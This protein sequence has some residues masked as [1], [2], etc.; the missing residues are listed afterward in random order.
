MDL[1][2]DEFL[3][4][5]EW[6]QRE[7]FRRK[8]TQRGLS[9][10]GVEEMLHAMPRSPWEP[11]VDWPPDRVIFSLQ[12]LRELPKAK[13]L[14]NV[15]VAMVQRAYEMYSSNTDDDLRLR[16]DEP[17]LLAAAGGDAGL[18]L[19]A[20]KVLDQHPP[21]LL[22][23]WSGSGPE[24]TPWGRWLYQAVMPIFG[25][26]TTVEDYLAAQ[27][28]LVNET[29]LPLSPK[30]IKPSRQDERARAVAGPQTA[31]ATE[32]TS[33][34]NSKKGIFLSHAHADRPLADLLR[35]TLVLAGVPQQ[36][37]FYSSSRSTGI[38]YG[39]EVRPYL[40]RTLREAGLVIELISETFLT[41]PMCLMELGG[42][43]TLGTSTYPMVVPPLT[44][45]MAVKQIGNIHMGI[46]APES[47]IDDLFD[48]L[49]DRLAKD[50]DILVET[51]P[52][53]HAIREFKNMLPEKL[54]AV[55]STPGRARQASRTTGSKPSSTVPST[56][57]SDKAPTGTRAS[58]EAKGALR[59]KL[60]GGQS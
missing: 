11:I 32:V 17:V 43:W 51:R 39:E 23:G 55:A 13:A 48:E 2:L 19:R 34:A 5:G 36:R 18:L 31:G 45:D 50:V 41:R 7:R 4:T 40:Q 14:L 25:G 60:S 59:R 47:E 22:G 52:W 54:A 21:S 12:V 24:S 35:T 33:S 53:N 6:P 3:Q 27:A 8:L 15:C 49:H 20:I 37:I 26:V 44:R 9:D 56:V 38:P 1:A 28:K 10:L 46:L 16:S 57:A 42:A 58:G 29:V 30:Q